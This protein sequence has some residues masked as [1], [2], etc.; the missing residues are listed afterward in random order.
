[1]GQHTF[2][3]HLSELDPLLVEAVQ[4]PQESLEHHFVFKVGQERSQRFRRQ[5]LTGNDAGRS[6][7]G[8]SFI[9]VLILFS[10]RK[11]HILGSHIR[12]ELLLACA[13]LNQHIRFRLA[14]TESDELKRN[15]IRTL[16]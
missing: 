9:P 12:T 1:M 3:Q 10:A 5:F 16:V 11:S 4:I 13:A 15:N 14:F 8:K 7:S 2:R 6:V